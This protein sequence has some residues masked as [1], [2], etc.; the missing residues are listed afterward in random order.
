[1]STKLWL[2]ALVVVGACSPSP[3][4]APVPA[5]PRA[6]GGSLVLVGGGAKPDDAVRT[7]VAL[8]GGEGA[9]IVVLPLATSE[10]RAAGGEYIELFRRHGVRDIEVVQIDDRRDAL[11]GAH[12]AAVR[13]ATGVWFS[14]GD[15]RR[16]A[17]RIVDTPLADA[18]LAMK[19]DGGVVGGTSAGTACQSGVMLTGDGDATV[20]ARGQIGVARGLDLMPGVILDTHFVA[21]RRHHRLISAVLDHPDRLGIGIDEDTAIWVKPDGTFEVFGDGTVLVYDATGHR[22]GATGRIPGTENDVR[23]QVLS[24]GQGYDL[25]ARHEVTP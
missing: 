24:R 19:Q 15:Q 2:L 6:P 16:I 12:V 18:L 4:G 20:I 7:F 10:S 11:R 14:G 9:R 8:A 13:Q 1:M 21:R 3:L 22:P 25:R 17:A 5:L 23:M